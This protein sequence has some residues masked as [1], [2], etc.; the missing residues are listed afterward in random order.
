M[1]RAQTGLLV[2]RPSLEEGCLTADGDGEDVEMSVSM[3]GLRTYCFF[4]LFVFF[5]CLISCV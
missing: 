1:I 2:G 4:F 3:G 5:E